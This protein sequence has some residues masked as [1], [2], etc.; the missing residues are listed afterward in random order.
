[1]TTKPKAPRE[2]APPAYDIRD[3]QAMYA[4]QKGEATPE[5]QRRALDWIITKAAITYDLPYGDT[6][7]GSNIMIGRQFVGKQIVKLMK[8]NPQVLK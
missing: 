4:L 3:C 8:L 5:Q 2:I 6:D 1:M 7:R